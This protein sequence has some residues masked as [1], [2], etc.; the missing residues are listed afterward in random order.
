MTTELEQRFD[1][2]NR[3]LFGGKLRTVKVK[4]MDTAAFAEKYGSDARGAFAG[5]KILV[6][7]DIF[8]NQDADTVDRIILHEMVHLDTL[9]EAGDDIHGPVFI[10]EANRVARLMGW[11]TIPG[12]AWDEA[13]FWP[14]RSVWLDPQTRKAYA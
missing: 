6:R 9:R 14:S 13:I 3:R 1:V 12:D 4:T 5:T 2:L 8:D 7:K 10:R 11:D